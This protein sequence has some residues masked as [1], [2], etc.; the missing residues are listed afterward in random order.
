MDIIRIT[1][2]KKLEGEVQLQGSKNSALPIMAACIM[3]RD[4]VILEDIPAISF[5][6]VIKLIP[7]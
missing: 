5:E 4:T 6:Y 2:S 7:S 1:G 3:T